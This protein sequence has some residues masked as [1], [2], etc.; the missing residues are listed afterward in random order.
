DLGVTVRFVVIGTPEEAAQFC[1]Q[2]GTADLCIAD[3]DKLTYRAMNLEDFNLF[4]L[5]S[6]PALKRRRAENKAAG[7]RQNWGVTKLKNSA[8]LP[9]AALVAR[10][11][12]ILWL[13]RGSH[14]G[15]LPQMASMLE[16][17]K[18]KVAIN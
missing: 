13:Y 18:L 9:G 11:G 17:A 7:F 5:F 12:S 10:D 2:H 15:D 14:P 3:P 1:G 16:V 8:Q 6:D 4:K